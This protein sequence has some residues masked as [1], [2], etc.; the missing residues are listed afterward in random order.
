MNQTLF[1]NGKEIHIITLLGKG[2]G[3]YSYLVKLDGQ[4]MVLKQIH[5]EPCDYYTFGNK[6][7]AER[8]D[9]QKLLKAGIRIPKLLDVHEENEWILKE[10]ID[11]PTVYELVCQDQMSEELLEQ[12][13]KMAQTAYASG[14]NL[15]YF[16]TNFI[17]SGELLYYVDYECNLYMEQWDFEHWG[18]RYW[19]KTP[20]FL[21]YQTDH[22]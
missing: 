10:F 17:L 4:K 12:G 3:G 18:I 7:E 8:S 5:H 14:L 6:L 13:L 20:E 16:P 2:K 1:W 9:Y 15:D 19:S 21:A 11:G 22:P